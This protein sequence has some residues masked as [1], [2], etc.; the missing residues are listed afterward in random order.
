MARGRAPFRGGRQVSQRRQTAWAIGVNGTVAHSTSVAQLYSVGAVPSAE[1]LTIVRIRGTFLA[2]LVTVGS[3]NDGFKGAVGIGIVTDEAFT[4]GI[5]SIP[6]P[7]SDEE[8]EL[9]IWHSFFHIIGASTSSPSQQ[10]AATVRLE[11]DSKA[12]RKFPVGNT[13]FAAV[14]VVESGVVSGESHIDTRTLV[15]LS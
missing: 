12:M 10:P 11:V 1:G 2:Y 3:N 7:F 14:E 6:A 5:A 4:A 9:W 13:L 8:D 15:K